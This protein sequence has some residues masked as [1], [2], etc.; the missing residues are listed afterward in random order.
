MHF[1]SAEVSVAL[2][3]VPSN[4]DFGLVQIRKTCNSEDLTRVPCYYP[5]FLGAR[6]SVENVR[7]T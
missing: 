1:K 3:G 4:T 7:I 6:A 2:L 5:C